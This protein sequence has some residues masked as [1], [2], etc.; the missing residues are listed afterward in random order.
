MVY[1]RS[2]LLL[3]FLFV[4]VGLILHFQLGIGTAIYP[5]L[6]ALVLMVTH[7][8]FNNVSAAFVLLR[9]GKIDQAERLIDQVK[10]PE[11]LVKQHRAYYHFTKGMISLQRNKLAE[12]K[13]DLKAALQLGLRTDNDRAL[14]I[15]NLAHICYLNKENEE[16]RNYLNE[17][18]QLN[19]DDLII[20]Q[21]VAEM[22]K[23]MVY[24]EN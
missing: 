18:K 16:A 19:S 7:F 13:T 14:A 1:A 12:G 3:V 24:K 9:R 5:Y 21:K 8:I 22:E 10:K 15:L 17:A 23:A 20:K 4:I 2:R 6:G 11:W